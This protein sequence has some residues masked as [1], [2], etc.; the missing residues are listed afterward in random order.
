MPLDSGHKT[1]NRNEPGLN[2][3]ILCCLDMIL[4][5]SKLEKYF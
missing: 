2:M 5:Q 4:D 1:D 3:L